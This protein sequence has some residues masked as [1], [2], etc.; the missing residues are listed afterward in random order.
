MIQLLYII[1]I[2]YYYTTYIYIY[3]YI[4][5]LYSSRDLSLDYKH[6]CNERRNILQVYEKVRHGKNRHE[7]ERNTRLSLTH[8]AQGVSRNIMYVKGEN[9]KGKT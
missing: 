4:C 5:I 6:S 8:Q 9:K 7:A 1:H 2:I 3:I